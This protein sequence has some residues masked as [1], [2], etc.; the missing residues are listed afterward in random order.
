M[1][2]VGEGAG[3]AIFRLIEFLALGQTSRQGIHHQQGDYTANYTCN[4]QC[5]E[6][7]NI[8]KYQADQDDNCGH[9]A[10]IINADAQIL[11][12]S[13]SVQSR[14]VRMQKPFAGNFGL[15]PGRIA[16]EHQV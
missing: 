10:H 12:S 1:T 13:L 15:G 4:C 3:L 11:G 8:V 2:R 14:P 9:Q 6:A 5:S 7:K 16:V